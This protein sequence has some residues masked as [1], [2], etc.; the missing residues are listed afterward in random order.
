MREMATMP[1]SGLRTSRTSL[2]QSPLQV[3]TT[4]FGAN[5]RSSP[6]G[7]DGQ[8]FDEAWLSVMGSSVHHTDTNLA[9]HRQKPSY[10]TWETTHGMQGSATLEHL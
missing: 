6:Q 2:D 3:R 8:F 1:G 10:L 9:V 7:I 4:P 5:S